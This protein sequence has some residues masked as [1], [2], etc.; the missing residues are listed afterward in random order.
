MR[1]F[2]LGMAPDERP[3]DAP[4]RGGGFTLV[5]LLV[6]STIALLVTASLATLFSL[7]ARTASTTQAVVDLADRMRTAAWKLRSDLEGVTCDPSIGVG[8]QP[9]EGYFELIEGPATDA[10]KP[11]RQSISYRQGD[12]V[13]FSGTSWVSLQ[14]SNAGTQPDTLS[15]AWS[16]NPSI[17]G[18]IDDGLLFTSRSLGKPFTGRFS[19][20]EDSNGNGN[21][22]LP[23]ERDRNS[24]LLPDTVFQIES[25]TAEIAW[26]CRPAAVQP[27]SEATLFTLYRR[28]NLV[29]PYVGTIPFLEGELISVTGNTSPN[30]AP[31]S[32]SIQ[33]PWSE[34]S[35]NSTWQRFFT[36][37]GAPN[38]FYDLS[39]RREREDTN[40]NNA[41]DPGE[42]RNANNILENYLIPNSLSDLCERRN[43]FWRQSTTAPFLPQFP[44]VFFPGG[45]LSPTFDGTH[46]EG[47][48][49]VLNNV[50]AFDVRVFDPYAPGHSNGGLIVFPGDPAFPVSPTAP[51]AMRGAYVDLG[52]GVPAPTGFSAPPDTPFFVGDTSANAFP[53]AG[54]SPFQGFGL[55]ASGAPA[56]T[57]FYSLGSWPTAW[58]PPS[59]V[60]DTWNPDPGTGRNGLDDGGIVGIPD[61]RAEFQQS[62]AYPVPLRG[63]EVRIRCYEPTTKQIRQITIRHSFIRK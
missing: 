34:T 54:F 52:W 8:E 45:S 17:N 21:L 35:A 41:I 58:P 19:Y 39:V 40:G 53:G 32:I 49:V 61:D 11:W 13:T 46:R 12:R 6:A 22:D 63:I 62:T 20:T 25:S 10:G 23:A 37:L 24:N 51:I 59:L 47:E 14:N 30:N 2:I 3:N 16:P 50:I 28:Q 43:R 44:F 33:D 38:G 15:S 56:N 4:R 5:E 48:D 1:R 26:F 42:D 9:Q 7:F 31:N 57:P 36:G 27:T 29:L 55:R 18:D 60:Y